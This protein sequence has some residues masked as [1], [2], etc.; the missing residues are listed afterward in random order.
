MKILV[1]GLRKEKKQLLDNFFPNHDF[2]VEELK[3]ASSRAR[4]VASGNSYDLVISMSYFV[5]HAIEETV[6]SKIGDTPW[7]RVPGS[8]SNLKKEI[9]KL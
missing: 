9:G 7:I 5:S 2:V 3:S 1:I 8:I 6:L 4:K